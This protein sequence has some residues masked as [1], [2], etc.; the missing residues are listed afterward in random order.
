MLPA[1]R[2]RL[3]VDR[4]EAGSAVPGASVAVVGAVIGINTCGSS[5]GVDGVVD[6]RREQRSGVLRCGQF[7]GIR[8]D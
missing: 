1:A 2:D 7:R 6:F 3:Y 5:V 4:L 8:F